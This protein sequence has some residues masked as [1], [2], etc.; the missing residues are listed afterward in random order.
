MSN[1]TQLLFLILF[2][3][4]RLFSQ[5]YSDWQPFSSDHPMA[6][7]LF[8]LDGNLACIADST[9]S[10]SQRD[11]IVSKAQQYLVKDLVFCPDRELMG[12]LVSSKWGE[13]K[14]SLL[15]WLK[16]GLMAY[17]TP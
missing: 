12:L 5:D 7:R 3:S 14:D 16:E 1:K 6:A 17:A 13:L 10:V 8:K 9:Y 4:C 15:M 11:S 2:F